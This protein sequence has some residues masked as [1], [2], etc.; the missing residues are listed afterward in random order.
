MKIYNIFIYED[1]KKV[2]VGGIYT[3]SSGWMYSQIF[4]SKHELVFGKRMYIEPV[5]TSYHI[6]QDEWTF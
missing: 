6:T 1:N 3:I 5:S 4:D 2:L